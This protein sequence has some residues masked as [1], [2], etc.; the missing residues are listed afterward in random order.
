VERLLRVLRSLD[1]VYRIQP[2]RRLEPN[3]SHLISPGHLNLMTRHG[4]LDLLGTVG[5]GMGYEDLVPYAA[6][7]DLGQG[8]RIDVLS[9]EMLI[10]LKEQLG[11]EKDRAMIPLL[12]RTLEQRRRTPSP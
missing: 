6:P 8:V 5:E 4:P 2:E 12:R 7:I 1:A 3:A 10:A 9:L 11:G